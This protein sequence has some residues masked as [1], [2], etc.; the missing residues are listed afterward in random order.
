MFPSHPFSLKSSGSSLPWHLTGNV[1]GVD[2]ALWNSVPNI[3]QTGRVD[4]DIGSVGGFQHTAVVCDVPLNDHHLCPLWGR[5]RNTVKTM[6]Y[7][8]NSEWGPFSSEHFNGTH[9]CNG[10]GREGLTE[11][12]YQTLQ[13]ILLDWFD[14]RQHCL[15]ST[16]THTTHFLDNQLSNKYR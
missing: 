7:V 9:V 2:E 5:N 11:F 12:V 3:H 4:D 14:R 15:A 1:D 16:R 13:N 10:K 6:L 8:C